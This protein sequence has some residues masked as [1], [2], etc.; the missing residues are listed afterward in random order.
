MLVTDLHG[1]SHD[2]FQVIKTYEGLKERGEVNYMVFMG[3]LIHAYPGSKDDSLFIVE[4][5]MARGANMDHSDIICLLGNH[6]MV[7]IYHIPLIRGHLEFTSWF[8]RR[9][10]SKRSSVIDFFKSMPMALRTIGGVLVHHTGACEGYN[11]RDVFYRSFSFLK[12]FS[13]QQQLDLLRK[14][15]PDLQPMGEYNLDVG[16]AFM[17]TQTGLWLWQVLMNGNERQWGKRYVSMVDD[18]L[19]FMSEDRSSNPLRVL[20]TGHIG[21]DYGVDLVGDKQVRLCSSAGCLGDLEKKYLLFSATQKFSN[22]QQ[23]LPYCYDLY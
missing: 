20:V 10:S 13:H 3:D 9:I 19:V 18:F 5:L 11:P 8:E 7:H 12:N 16:A 4:D 6:E 14:N 1:N 21:A 2:Y 23:L 22:A 15:N 17:E